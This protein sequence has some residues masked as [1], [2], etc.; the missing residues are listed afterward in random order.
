MRTCLQVVHSESQENGQKEANR[1]KYEED[2]ERPADQASK[3][4]EEK[5]DTT[6]QDAMETKFPSDTS[7]ETSTGNGSQ[8]R[9]LRRGSFW[10]EPLTLFLRWCF[11]S[12]V[13]PSDTLVRRSISQQ[14]T[15]VSITIDDPVRTVRQPSPPRG[16]VSCI[17]HISNLVRDARH[18]PPAAVTLLLMLCVTGAG[19]A[20]HP[21]P[22]Q[23]AAGPDGNPGGGRLLD[24]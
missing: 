13:T 4:N 19:E 12:P 22:A 24:R 6:C 23:R 15:G 17:V 5:M 1:S 7:H 18:L 20:V 16:K 2:D 21:R 9:F 8:G 11:F 14:R 3:E 10:L